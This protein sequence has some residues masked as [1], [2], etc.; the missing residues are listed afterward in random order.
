MSPPAGAGGMT[1]GDIVSGNATRFGNV[2]AYRSGDRTISHAQLH[3]RAAQLVSAM[4][5]AGV[6]R[7]DR[8]VIVARNHIRFGEVL[9]ACYLSGIIA[10]PISV[11]LAAGEMRDGI[12]RVSPS[13]VFCDDE[14]APT[15]GALLPDGCQTIVLGPSSEPNHIAY[16]RFLRSGDLVPSALVAEP[17]DIALLLFTSGTTGGAKCCML[18]HREFY[19]VAHTMNAEMR[20]GADDRALINMPMFHV[21]ALAIIAGIHARGGTVVLQSQF[22][23]AEALRLITTEEIS[24]LHLAPVMLQRLVDQMESSGQLTSVRTVLYVAAPMTAPILRAAMATLPGAGFVNLYGQTEAIVSGLPPE[25]H[26]ADAPAAL[27]SV[28]FPF[29]GVRLRIVDDHGNDLPDGQPGEIA[30][31][32]DTMFRGY[33]DDHA[34]TL[35]TIRDGWCYTG[36]VGRI[37]EH[38]LLF[39]V[40]RKKDVI[41]TGGEN[42][43][44]PE[45]EDV[46]GEIDGIAACAVVGCADPRWGEA[47]CAVVVAAPGTVVTLEVLQDAVRRKLARFK[48]PRKLVL[49]NELPLLASGKVDKKRL[50]AMVA[51]H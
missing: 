40:D 12:R 18:G 42:V 48:V 47:V 9:A 13:L 15:V 16:E 21:G 8:V 37:D 23:P 46:I 44:S 45:V 38:G 2:V 22:D 7:Q 25:S 19:R 11:R 4:V 6:R 29:P 3:Q 51:Q 49:L 10:A 33:W 30:V 34:A 14:F 20:S 1:L 39:L 26:C 17:G 35:N 36:D 5:A 28:G 24:V 31:R 41:I 50:R 27:R 32:S 43:Y